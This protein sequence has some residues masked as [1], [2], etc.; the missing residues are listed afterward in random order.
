MTLPEP[1]LNSFRENGV[2]AHRYYESVGSTNQIALEWLE[3]GAP[4]QA[5]VFANHQSDGRGRLQRKWV[6]NP[7]A[8]IAVSIILRPTP[9]E[10]NKLSLASPLAG[11]ALADLL[12]KAYQ[13]PA[14][15]KWPNDVLINEAKTAGI[16]T[17]VSWDGS[18]LN[19][20]VIGI[21]INITPAAL[22][23]V[24]SLQYPATCL[25][26]HLNFPLDRF[27][28]LAHFLQSLFY[29]RQRLTRDLFFETWKEKLAFQGKTVYIKGNDG[30]VLCTGT[31]NGI[32]PNGD[33][34]IKTAENKIETFTVGDVHLRRD[35]NNQP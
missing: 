35:P 24:E 15:I 31:I 25:Q 4:D 32:L 9:D 21:G 22:P 30:T 14:Q 34:A 13:I 3:E 11:V 19:G 6:T 27:Q 7:G 17:E 2:K 8:A 12:Q 28:F 29:W 23:P 16:L 1:I 20:I 33:I 26:E 10:V 18:R 5:I